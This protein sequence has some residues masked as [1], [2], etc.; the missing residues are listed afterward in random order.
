MNQAEFHLKL[1]I[2]FGAEPPC[3]RT[4]WIT[5]PRDIWVTAGH[6]EVFLQPKRVNLSNMAVHY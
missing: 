2:T 5:S 1:A 3:H 4:S 6:I